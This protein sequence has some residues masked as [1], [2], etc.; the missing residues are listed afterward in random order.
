[1]LVHRKPVEAYDA[2]GQLIGSWDSMLEAAK[3]SGY[4]KTLIKNC[5]GC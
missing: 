1:M 5:A 4:S 2:D 3:K